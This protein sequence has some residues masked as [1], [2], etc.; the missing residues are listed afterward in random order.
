[1]RALIQR[2][3]SATLSVDGEVI[4]HIDA[5]LL[6]SVGI[7]RHDTMDDVKYM[8]HK[9]SALRIFVRD[10]KLRESVMDISGEIMLVSNFSLQAEIRSGTRPNFNHAMDYDLADAMY[11]D[12]MD[13]LKSEGVRNVVGGSFGHHM[14]I[15]CTLDGPFSI[16]LDTKND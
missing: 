12:L 3:H 16:V 4:S 11:H 1:M 7:N 14:H 13:E 2:V 9:I 15:D 8:A 5:G 10:G 6:V